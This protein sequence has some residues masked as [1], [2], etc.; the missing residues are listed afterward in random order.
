[1]TLKADAGTT[2]RTKQ[3][4]YDIITECGRKNPRA[5]IPETT[6][7][8]PYYLTETERCIVLVETP[9]KN[10]SLTSYMLKRE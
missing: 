6:F 8:G 1:M 2:G 7:P 10:I 9:S 5:R 4:L 3:D